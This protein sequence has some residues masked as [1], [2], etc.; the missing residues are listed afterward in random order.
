MKLEEKLTPENT[1]K[2]IRYMTQCIDDQWGQA[3]VNLTTKTYKGKPI[4]QSILLHELIEAEEFEERG[5]KF[6]S[7]ELK[8]M[9]YDE[10]LRQY[11]L[12]NKSINENPD[13]HLSALRFQY[14]F[15]SS[16]AQ[17]QGLEISPGVI[18]KLSPISPVLEVERALERYN[19][20]NFS[21]NEYGEAKNF[22]FKLLKEEPIYAKIFNSASKNGSGIYFYQRY[23]SEV[24]ELLR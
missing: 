21:E 16:I 5:Y 8:K 14:I 7:P 18:L 20:L 4:S 3:L 24:E 2:V 22:I 11:K 23:S 9:T 15:L 13:I 17:R 10:K 6:A 19:D 12:K 1:K